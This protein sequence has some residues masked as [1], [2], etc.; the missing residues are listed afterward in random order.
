MT[1]QSDDTQHWQQQR[2]QWLGWLDQ[3]V[4]DIAAWSEHEGWGVNRE[5]KTVTEP[6]LGTY[7]APV[8]HVQ[9]SG[10]RIQVN[11]IGLHMI[12]AEGRVDLE[13]WPTLN[14]VKLVRRQ[15]QWQIVT[16][17]NV[18]LRLPWCEQTFVQLAQDLI[19]MP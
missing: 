3:L 4:S 2:D 17:S 11:P 6:L 9:I 10:G 19:G 8:L 7:S 13:G 12:G 14:R 18:P 16:D 1:L 15:E 5:Q